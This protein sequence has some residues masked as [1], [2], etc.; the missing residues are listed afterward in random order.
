MLATLRREVL[1]HRIELA[2]A[3]SA[4]REVQ[5]MVATRHAVTPM[6]FEALALRDRFGA[7]DALFVILARQLDA[8]LV[9]SDARLARAAEGYVRVRAFV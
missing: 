6:L 8:T 3:L 2:R 1:N 7:H 9:T 4:L 5:Q